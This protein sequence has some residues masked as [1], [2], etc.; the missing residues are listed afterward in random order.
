MKQKKYVLEAEPLPD[1]VSHLEGGIEELKTTSTDGSN[2]LT[3][4]NEIT[5]LSDNIPDNIQNFDKDITP[6]SNADPENIILTNIQGES[7]FMN[8]IIEVHKRLKKV[9]RHP[10]GRNGVYYIFGL[11]KFTAY[12]WLNKIK[13]RKDKH[14]K[15]QAL[16]STYT[17][18]MAKNEMFSIINK[19][20]F[21]QQSKELIASLLI[22]W[23][24]LYLALNNKAKTTN[25]QN[26]SLKDYLFWGKT[27]I[28]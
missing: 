4:I 12:K 5:Q 17:H 25:Y 24:N 15:I 8:Q 14:S 20:H 1:F 27:V 26:I 28:H 22:Y 13:S 2:L 7:D 18:S 19:D 9:G 23:T 3:F 6:Y 21:T 16:P 10:L 11:V